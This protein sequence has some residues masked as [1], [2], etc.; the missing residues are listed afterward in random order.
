MNSSLLIATRNPKK[1][2]ELQQL[3]QD[4][5]IRIL[6]LDDIEEIP[7]IVEDGLSFTENATKKARESAL[8]S[9]YT[10]LADDSGLV[11]D[12]LEG[13]P[14]VLSARFAGEE[15][16]DQ[17]N[18]EK[19]LDM[20]KKVSASQRTARF[21]CVIAVSSP[22]GIV[23]TVS[24]VCEGSI[25]LKPEGTSGFGYDPLFIPLGYD[26]TFAQLASSIKN[27]ISHR[28]KALEKCQV[29]LQQFLD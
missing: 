11:V 16:G 29:L 18:N 12:A 14:G 26:Q 23:E 10:C 4:K 27:S 15:A 7:E 1:K 24:G 8:L 25:A 6:T 20:M 21:I 2:L 9:G 17:K 5:N 28:G 3:L 22:V 19:L 13:K